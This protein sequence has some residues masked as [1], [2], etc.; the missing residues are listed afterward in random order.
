MQLDGMTLLAGRAAAEEA[1]AG[2]AGQVG[3]AAERAH[4]R[5]SAESCPLRCSPPSEDRKKLMKQVIESIP[6]KVEELFGATLDWDA[7]TPEFVEQRIEPWVKKKVGLRAFPPALTPADCA[8]HWRGGE[9][10]HPVHQ[11]QD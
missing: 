6:V 7:V 3:A 5:R 1:Q 9:V 11:R 8:V 4:G 10:A 2:Q